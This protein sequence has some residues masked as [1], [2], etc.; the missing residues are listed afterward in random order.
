MLESVQNKVLTSIHSAHFYRNCAKFCMKLEYFL[1]L[2]FIFIKYKSH[3]SYV[4]IETM[5]C[6]ISVTMDLK[7]IQKVQDCNLVTLR[8]SEVLAPS[9]LKLPIRPDHLVWLDLKPLGQLTCPLSGK[10]EIRSESL[11]TLYLNSPTSLQ[12]CTLPSC[13]AHLSES[14]HHPQQ[15]QVRDLKSIL[16]PQLIP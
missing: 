3:S 2:L 14:Y 9:R 4:I 7:Q 15:T 10:G 13:I 11:P 5:T 6:M 12:I 1:N 16:N 8:L